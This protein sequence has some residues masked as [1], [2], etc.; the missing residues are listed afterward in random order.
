MSVTRFSL[1]LSSLALVSL[2]SCGGS[3]PSSTPAAA[4]Q[5]PAARPAAPVTA[6]ASDVPALYTEVQAERGAK[7]YDR[8]CLE[9]HTQVEFKERQFLFAWEGSSV[10]Q[11]YRYIAENMPDDGPGSLQERDYID[12]MAYILQMNGYPAGM[13]ELTADV[14]RMGA[15]PF[16]S[17]VGDGGS[18]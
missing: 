8:V 1:A 18:R 6:P 5:A 3:A 14:E 15:V 11:I 16:E 10:A 17:H 13:A 7:V 9:C 2:F 4:P 12:T